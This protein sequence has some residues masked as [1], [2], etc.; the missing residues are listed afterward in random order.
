MRMKATPYYIYTLLCILL[1]TACT[2]SDSLPL[3]GNG[4]EKR[5][6]LAYSI[7]NP[8][9][10]RAP[11]E[12]WNE[13]WN[14]NEVDRLDLFIFPADGSNPIHI[15]EE[16]INVTDNQVDED[17]NTWALSSDQLSPDDIT[18][19]DEIYLIANC[20]AVANVSSKDG[21]QVVLTNL[22]CFAKQ[23]SFVMTG[24]GT[25]S[26]DN[27]DNSDDV[28]IIEDGNDKIIQVDLIR[29]A[30][31]IRLS[32]SES[33]ETDWSDNI[34]YRFYHYSQS[35]TLLPENDET[36]IPT[37]TLSTY[38]D[39][40]QDM[41]T[42]NIGTTENYYTPGEQLV[43]Y[44]YPNNW[45]DESKVENMNQEEPID[46][47]KQTYILLYAP[48][49]HDSE[50]YYYYKIPVNYR[51]HIDNDKVDVSGYEHLYCLQR[52]YIYDITVTIDRA[53][54]TETEPVTPKLYYQVMPFEEETIDIPAFE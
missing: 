9:Q 34:A 35:A 39:E 15:S 38:P 36:Y 40:N 7:N 27:D 48:Y 8:V 33:S 1:F 4:Q 6:I 19:A 32:F 26:D 53:G 43:L 5:I 12:G 42:V 46:E 20:P 21:L 52:N 16:N 47:T 13:G 22:Q 45:L 44:S 50:N 11:D 2:E 24:S 41:I 18:D 14:E 28:R 37:I 51:L 3:E 17:Y 54:G 31:K 29:V 10:S 49:P 30:A 23:S 25:G